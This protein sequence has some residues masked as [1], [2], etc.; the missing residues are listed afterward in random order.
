VID[1]VVAGD[2]IP[3]ARKGRDGGGVGLGDDAVAL[4]AVALA[5]DL[6]GQKRGKGGKK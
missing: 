6:V 4:G 1:A 5:M 3:G 2:T